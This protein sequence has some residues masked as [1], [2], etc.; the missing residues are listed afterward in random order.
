MSDIAAF[1]RY[2]GQKGILMLKARVL[3]PIGMGLDSDKFAIV[4]NVAV[5]YLNNHPAVH[6]HDV[7]ALVASEV[8]ALMSG[9]MG[10]VCARW[11]HR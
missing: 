7:M 2:R 1:H 6:G 10:I 5:L 9:F 11:W 4:T 3:L 8:N